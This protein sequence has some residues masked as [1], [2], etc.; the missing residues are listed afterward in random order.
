MGIIGLLNVFHREL[1]GEELVKTK[2]EKFEGK[3][4]ETYEYR[5]VKN[6]RRG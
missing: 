1:F 5:K 4:L 6:K 3:T 2:E